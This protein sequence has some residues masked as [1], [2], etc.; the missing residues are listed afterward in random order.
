M[1][2]SLCI[3]LLLSVVGLGAVIRTIP[4]VATMFINAGLFGKD[5]CKKDRDKKV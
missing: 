2:V 4:A 5:L 3:N 1:I